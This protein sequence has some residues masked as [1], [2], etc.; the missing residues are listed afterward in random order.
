MDG[1]TA[2]APRTD[3]VSPHPFPPPGARHLA[4]PVAAAAG[5][6]HLGWVPGWK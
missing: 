4:P 5:V 3:G 2:G 6:P 1:Q